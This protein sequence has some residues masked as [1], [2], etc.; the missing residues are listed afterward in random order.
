MNFG[1]YNDGFFNVDEKHGFLPIKDPLDKISMKYFELR[2]TM[3]DFYICQKNERK[4]ILGIPDK[5]VN[6]VKNIP[7]FEKLIYQ[8]KDPFILQSLFRTYTFLASG[9]TLESSYQEFIKTGNYGNARTFLPKN[10]ARPLVVLSEK[11]EV[12]PW[13]DYH[14]AYALGNYKRI[15][16]SGTLHWKNLDMICKFSGT[17]DEIGFIMLHVYINELSPKLIESIRDENIEL[18]ANVMKQMNERRKEMWKASNYKNYNDFRI[19][20]MG[21]KGNYKIFNNGVIFEDCFDNEPQEFRGQTGAQDDIIPT[22]DI[23][24]GIIDYYPQNQLTKYLYDLRTYRPKVIQKF[25]DDLLNYYKENPLFERLKHKNDDKSIID[26]LKIID[27]VYYF[28]NGHWQFVQKYIISNT[29]YEIAT[30]GTPI[31]SWLINQ[32]EAVLLY[33]NKILKYLV[34]KNIDESFKNYNDYLNILNSYDSKRILLQEQKKIL[35]E[36]N[37]DSDLLFSKNVELKLND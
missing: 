22:M 9:Y 27:E 28:R 5:I 20:I 30:G 31:I 21:I 18:C 33:E 2:K 29:K 3:E 7:N 19:F 17:S 36:K 26:L 14:Y 32:I 8:E 1:T 15:D 25:L 34:E 16:K 12:Y 35:L 6:C 13:L 11:L 37:Y 24:T 23:F 4:G 10:I